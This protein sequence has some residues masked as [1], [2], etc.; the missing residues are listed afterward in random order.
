MN[1][2]PQPSFPSALAAFL[3]G[4]E[5]RGAVL[6]ELQC[7]DA[8]AGDAAL[9]AAMRAF[10]LGAADEPMADWPR[11]FWT[12]LLAAPQLRRPPPDPHWP[13]ELAWLGRLTPAPRAALLLRLASGLD[14]AEAAAVLAVAPASYRLA[15]RRALPHRDDG[16]AD[17]GAWA[18]LREQ[19]HR[20]IK[21]LPAERLAHLARL[22]EAAIAGTTPPG[23][24]AGPRPAPGLRRALWAGVALCVALLA[25]TWAWPWLQGRAD[26]DGIRTDDLR[27]ERPAARF[28]EH[29]ALLGHRDFALL[30]DPAGLAASED[31][32]FYSWLAAQAPVAPEALQADLPLPAEAAVEIAGGATAPPRES[33]DEP[34]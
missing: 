16:R 24:A 29:T 2:S 21:T 8:V 28:D 11:R 12:L 25:A 4:V 33:S 19:V 26:Q 31:L 23:R 7:G 32:G 3:R 13:R 22:R 20:R 1:P 18:A 14:E 30:A 9:A 27:A 15:L 10:R 6:A 17:P 34:R 5:R